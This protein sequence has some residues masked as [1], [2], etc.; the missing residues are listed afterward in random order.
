MEKELNSS[1]MVQQTSAQITVARGLRY[2]LERKQVKV[3]DYLLQPV[4]SDV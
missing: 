1:K 3:C 2:A 4:S